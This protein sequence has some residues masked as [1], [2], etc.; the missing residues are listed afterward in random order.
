[1]IELVRNGRL[2][3]LGVGLVFLWA[4]NALTGVGDLVVDADAGGV[5]A[6]VVDVAPPP[7]NDGGP[8]V[9]DGGVEAAPL[10]EGCTCVPALP[11]DAG[12]TGPYLVYMGDRA[13]APAC[14]DAVPTSTDENTGTPEGGI[15]CGPCEC[16]GPHAVNCTATLNTF[17]DPN[18]QTPGGDLPAATCQTPDGTDPTIILSY[19]VSTAASG[20]FC[21]T[22][23]GPA[24]KSTVTWPT[25]LRR[26]E[27]T[28]PFAATTGCDAGDTC[29]P[30]GAAPFLAH[31]CIRNED[32]TLDCPAPW[33][34][35]LATTFAGLIDG[36]GC[37]TSGCH[38]GSVSGAK[39]VGTLNEFGTVTDCSGDP[40]STVPMPTSDCVQTSATS[41]Q[42]QANVFSQG[43]SCT[44]SGTPTANNNLQGGGDKAVVCCMP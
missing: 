37:S 19:K 13:S 44:A 29:V 22:Q 8:I 25:V 27:P 12:W 4:C 10:G 30:N 15:D 40:T 21:G 2:A 1:M 11:A 35:R 20:G 43:G 16:S 28:T 14:P 41:S 6:N 23:L 33:T 38:C 34:N 39:C 24:T 3:G 7:A 36:R 9:T 31:S 32:S 5:D 42:I 17:N 26:C 18:C